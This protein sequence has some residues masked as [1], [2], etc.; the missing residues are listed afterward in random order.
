MH[1]LIKYNYFIYYLHIACHFSYLLLLES[2]IWISALSFTDL[3][4]CTSIHTF[5]SAEM[6]LTPLAVRKWIHSGAWTSGEAALTSWPAL[7]G[8]CPTWPLTNGQSVPNEE[9]DQQRW[10]AAAEHLYWCWGSWHDSLAF[11]AALSKMLRCAWTDVSQDERSLAL[12]MLLVH[13]VALAAV[14]TTATNK[15]C[16]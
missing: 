16:L 15:V 12:A 4:F 13:L 8:S 7:I 6:V 11:T 5:T 3:S 9:R 10:L 14:W 1:Y 2:S